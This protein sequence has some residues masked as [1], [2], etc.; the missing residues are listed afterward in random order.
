MN[1]T[2]N[3]FKQISNSIHVAALIGSLFIALPVSAIL[4][5]A[6]GCTMNGTAMLTTCAPASIAGESSI[7]EKSPAKPCPL[8]QLR[9]GLVFSPVTPESHLY[10]IV[11]K[12]SI[13][14]GCDQ[15]LST[16]SSAQLL[17]DSRIPPPQ[18]SILR[19]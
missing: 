11:A 2:S 18:R 12:T 10:S 9:A 5:E 6:R 13:G 15:S 14:S 7:K 3:P 1:K 16:S 17:Y 8:L 19:I 4:Q